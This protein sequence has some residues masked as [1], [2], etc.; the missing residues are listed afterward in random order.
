MRKLNRYI[1]TSVAGAICLVLLVLVA[2]DAISALVDQLGQ[3][4]GQYTFVEV[5]IYIG[6]TLPGR[7]NEQIPFSA[8]VGCLIGLG[9]LAGSSELVVIRAAGVSVRRVVWAVIKPVLLFIAAGLLLGEYVTPYT[10]QIAESRRA[11]AQGDKGS[12]ESRFGLWNREGDEFMHF[13]AVLPNGKLYGVT[14]YKFDEQQRLLS[15]SFARTVIFQGSHWLEENLVI[16][17]FSAEGTSTESLPERRWQTELS[18][19]LLNILVL[20]PQ[21]LSIESLLSYAH[22]LEEQGGDSSKYW[23]V[24]WQKLL[25]PLATASLV[26]IAISFIFGPLRE[27]TMGFRI[28]S[29]VIVGI[30]FRTSQDLLGPASIVFGFSPL[31]AV[32]IPIAVCFLIGSLLLRRSR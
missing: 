5:L 31:V 10:D 21:A 28:F 25:Q 27:V 16:T 26:I 15:S 19:A 12:L 8:L 4:Q 17:H 6:M 7:I 14:R 32:M 1:A 29:G 20:E 2:L 30:V 9:I 13:N 11:L 23:L 3:V 24:F 18:P 22:Y